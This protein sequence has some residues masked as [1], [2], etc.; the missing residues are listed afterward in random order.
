[1]ISSRAVGIG[2]FGLLLSMGVA[3]GQTAAHYRDFQ[4]GGSVASV[5]ALT[6]VAAA[7]A[8]TVRARP[9]TLQELQWR[10]PYTFSSG[11][12]VDPV[13]QIVFGF[14]NDQLY[15]LVIDYD[16]DRTEG[17]TDADMVE[18]ISAMYGPTVKAVS[19]TNR[20]APA[21][22]DEESGTRVAGWGNA[23]YGAV[24]Y[25]SSYASGFRMIVTSVQLN[26]LARTAEA[27]A[28]RLDEHDAPQR[29]LARQKKEA[30]DARASKEKM[31]VAN[32]AAF[33]P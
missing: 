29:E 11:T 8:K 3:H 1:M 2:V 4:L 31:R 10:R 19:K 27:Q 23:E 15:R 20:E 12:P 17:M 24:L 5:S 28:V 26:A 30:D 14:Y 22:S 7:E 18:A 16:R 21:T 6:G 25:R 13:Q 33:R 32:K 9:A